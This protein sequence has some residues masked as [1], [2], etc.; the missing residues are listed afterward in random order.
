MPGTDALASVKR[1]AARALRVTGYEV[2]RTDRTPRE[3]VAAV[4]RPNFARRYAQTPQ[5]AAG[6]REKYREP[7]FG[8]IR[9][10]EA[11]ALLANV[12]DVFDHILMNASQEVHTVQVVESMRDEGVD[13]ESLILAALLHDV[14]KVLALTVEARA[15]LFGSTAPI[16]EYDVGIGL[17]Q[18]AL[19]WGADEFTYSR[20]QGR[21]PDHVSWLIRYHSL[22]PGRFEHLMDDRDREY[23]ERYWKDF[24]R[25][26]HDSKSIHKV[27]RTRL[28]DYRS[29]IDQVFPEPIAF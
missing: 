1:A 17:D 3:Q 11:L 10:T 27:P 25:F 16:G 9:V 28:R 22:I 23:H 21:V 29:L 24:T 15:N 13:D 20:V 4:A 2:H 6:L 5:A 7:V 8:E 14:G 19:I 12:I 18:C 26:D